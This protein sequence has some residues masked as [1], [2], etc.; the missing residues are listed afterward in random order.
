MIGVNV[1]GI[2]QSIAYQWWKDQSCT[3]GYQTSSGNSINIVSN[4]Q[5]LC[6]FALLAAAKVNHQ[7]YQW[8]DTQSK[9]NVV[10]QLKNLSFS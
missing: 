5:P 3:V 9:V 10:Y 1:S 8:Q 2:N 6:L 4:H 7:R